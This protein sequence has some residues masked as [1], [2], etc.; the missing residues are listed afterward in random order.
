MVEI[1]Y[2]PRPPPTC[3]LPHSIKGLRSCVC[4]EEIRRRRR[5]RSEISPP[6]F[7]LLRPTTTIPFLQLLLPNNLFKVIVERA[8][9]W[10]CSRRRR[11]HHRRRQQPQNEK[12]VRWSAV[13]LRPKYFLLHNLFCN[14]GITYFCHSYY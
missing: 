10:R 7:W 1:D 12:R 9:G 6:P 3:C 8:C 2:R 13:W 11:H 4:V 14:T 5:R